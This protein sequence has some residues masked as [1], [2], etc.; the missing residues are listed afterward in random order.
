M[1]YILDSSVLIYML[2]SFPRKA[3]KDLWNLF[4]H[5]CET[6]ETISVNEAKKMLEN[7][8]LTELLSHDWLKDN[9]YI[10]K[11]IT[12]KD[13]NIIKNVVGKG[14]FDEYSNSEKFM[15]K[16]PYSLP[17]TISKAIAEN[18]TLVV[19][20]KSKEFEF[21]KKIGEDLGIRVIETQDYLVQLLENT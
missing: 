10:F 5:S 12:Q 6:D 13:A 3:S 11:K 17:F 15:R 19:D 21:I 14:Y 8:E 16:L 7:H 9:S 4:E 2:E 1:E 18:L 20:K